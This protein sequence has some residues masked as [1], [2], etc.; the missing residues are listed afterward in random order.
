LID[1]DAQK[2]MLAI[3]INTYQGN[4]T[5]MITILVVILLILRFSNLAS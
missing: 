3:L 4:V 5:I 1:K 2:A